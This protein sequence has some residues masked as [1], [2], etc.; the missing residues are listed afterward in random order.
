MAIQVTLYQGNQDYWIFYWIFWCI[1]EL[2]S[3]SVWGI[4]FSNRV[5]V[6]TGRRCGSI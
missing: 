2:R 5:V 1:P 4:G 6:V 3:F